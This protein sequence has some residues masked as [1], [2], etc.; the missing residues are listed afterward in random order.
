[1]IVSM[2]VE[3]IYYRKLLLER[4]TFAKFLDLYIEKYGKQSFKENGDDYTIE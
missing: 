3:N 1:M 2:I 4:D